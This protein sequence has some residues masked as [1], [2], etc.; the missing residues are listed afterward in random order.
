MP[1][2]IPQIYIIIITTIKRFIVVTIFMNYN[3]LF[4]DEVH[5]C[6][7]SVI[8]HKSIYNLHTVFDSTFIIWFTLMPSG[9]RAF[10][11]NWK[12][13]MKDCL[14]PATG[15]LSVNPETLSYKY[16]MESTY[17]YCIF[18]CSWCWNLLISFHVKMCSKLLYGNTCLNK[19][20]L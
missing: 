10:K 15:T 20:V 11:P 8:I 2:L 18:V 5:S 4:T 19:G 3:Y 16:K 13:I 6:V 17:N 12:S 1:K 14:I 9:V 7:T